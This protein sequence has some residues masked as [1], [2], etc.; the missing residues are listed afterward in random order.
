MSAG[1]YSGHRIAAV[2]QS[3]TWN[4]PLSAVGQVSSATTTQTTVAWLPATACYSCHA[5]KDIY[6]NQA[7]P[8]SWGNSKM[9]LLSGADASGSFDTTL[10]INQDPAL[11]ADQTDV[12]LYDGVCLRCHVEAGS[13]AGVGISY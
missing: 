5:T 3:G 1:G 4:D 13:T 12:Q 11:G 8:H 9:W 2:A 6:G 10:P 7:F